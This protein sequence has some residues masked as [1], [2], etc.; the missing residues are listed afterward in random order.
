M[1]VQRLLRLCLARASGALRHAGAERLARLQ[2][3]VAAIPSDEEVSEWRRFLY[4]G[5][6]GEGDMEM[7]Q[8]SAEQY[9]S[10]SERQTNSAGP[11][12]SR[13]AWAVLTAG[14]RYYVDD[15]FC[16]CVCGGADVGGLPRVLTNVAI[17]LVQPLPGHAAGATGALGSNLNTYI[18]VY[19]GAGVAVTCFTAA[20]M[21]I[22]IHM[23]VS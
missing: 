8:F 17:R 23:Y 5:G 22:Y 11:L 4:G 13:C 15:A 9:T 2:R 14:G 18:H 19:M 3:Y 21:M 7:G 20:H 12:A 10:W 16:V 1:G 6:Y